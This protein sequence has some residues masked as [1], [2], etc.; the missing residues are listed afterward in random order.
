MKWGLGWKA[1]SLMRAE[2][3]V[4]T[5][6]GAAAVMPRRVLRPRPRP[7]L[8]PPRLIAETQE[9]VTSGLALHDSLCSQTAPRK[10][11]FGSLKDEDRIFTNLYGRHDWR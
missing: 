11:S 8:T 3:E 2:Q 9:S 5:K 4:L 6:V 1:P 7:L 10:T